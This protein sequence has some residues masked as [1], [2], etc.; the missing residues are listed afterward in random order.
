MLTR[1]CKRPSVVRGACPDVPV[2]AFERAADAIKVSAKR[3]LSPIRDMKDK[4]KQTSRGG[5]AVNVVGC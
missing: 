3:T 1:T 4:Y 2:R 5:L